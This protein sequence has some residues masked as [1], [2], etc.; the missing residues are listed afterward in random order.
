MDLSV[1][2]EVVH[3]NE[4]AIAKYFIRKQSLQRGQRAVAVAEVT[5]LNRAV[6]FSYSASV[7][8]EKTGQ[9]AY[10]VQ[11]RFTGNQISASSCP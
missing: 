9:V 6:D 1:V 7:H 3:F 5:N 2:P 4:L 8:S 11:V 10:L